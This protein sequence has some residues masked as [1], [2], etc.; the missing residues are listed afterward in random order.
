VNDQESRE[1]ERCIEAMSASLATRTRY[2]SV[3]LEF[4]SE[5]SNG[6][7]FSHTPVR[8]REAFTIA[9]RTL[10][11]DS[12]E[13][14]WDAV[15]LL[16]SLHSVHRAELDGCGQPLISILQRA[17]QI[18]QDARDVA[19]G[20]KTRHEWP[21]TNSERRAWRK[22]AANASIGF[23]CVMAFWAALFAILAAW[24]KRDLSGWPFVFA[25]VAAV[26]GWGAVKQFR[27]HNHIDGGPEAPP[28]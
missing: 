8:V 13:D 16:G 19:T 14:E 3:L 10:C 9:C 5:F 18:I 23:V 15:G 22:N 26:M 6:G 1:R 17:D 12:P 21:I 11:S 24:D 27:W 25:G 7:F 20:K 28:D 4:I 2:R